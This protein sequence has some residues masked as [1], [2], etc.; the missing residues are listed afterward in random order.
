[1]AVAIAWESRN[2]PNPI[3]ATI[4][5]ESGPL[6][7]I[8]KFW[9][10]YKAKQPWLSETIRYDY[11]KAFMSRRYPNRMML[12]DDEK[13]KRRFDESRRT[14]TIEKRNIFNKLMNDDHEMFITNPHSEPNCLNGQFGQCQVTNPLL[15]Q[16]LFNELNNMDPI[17]DELIIEKPEEIYHVDLLHHHQDYSIHSL[18]AQ[19]TANNE[20]LAADLLTPIGSNPQLTLKL[21][22]GLP[23][24][25]SN[26]FAMQ[27]ESITISKI[28][29]RP[30]Q[31]NY[32]RSERKVGRTFCP[33]KNNL[34][35][36]RHQ[37]LKVASA[38]DNFCY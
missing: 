36:H 7:Q 26:H 9:P 16:Y 25:D 23:I 3:Q 30:I 4:S 24:F 31:A 12:Q 1:M 32:S 34:P 38:L 28:V 22:N 20:L 5:L 15:T 37:T 8:Q 13:K 14:R 33:A 21:H 2:K 35:L 10:E 19:P 29:V 17:M 11:T 18:P 6:E 27:P